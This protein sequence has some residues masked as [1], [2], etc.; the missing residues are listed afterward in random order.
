M[1]CVCEWF[2]CMIR[3]FSNLIQMFNK[4]TVIESFVYIYIYICVI[5]CHGLKSF[6][7]RRYIY[8]GIC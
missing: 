3:L 7:V 6:V 8:D 2:V 1:M 4:I 5:E